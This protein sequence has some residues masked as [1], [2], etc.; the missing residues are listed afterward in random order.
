M[1]SRIWPV[2]H[3]IPHI[4]LLLLLLLSHGSRAVVYSNL[5]AVHIKGGERVAREVADKH[6]F[7]FLEEVRTSNRIAYPRPLPDCDPGKS[8]LAMKNKFCANVAGSSSTV[9]LLQNSSTF[10][11]VNHVMLLLPSTN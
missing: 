10:P 5:W 4:T 6:G 9:L 7:T 8:L 1:T 11:V 2:H 3:C